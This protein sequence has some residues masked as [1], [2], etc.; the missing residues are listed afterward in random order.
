M[1]KLKRQKELLRIFLKRYFFEVQISLRFSFVS[2]ENIYFVGF[3][4]FSQESRNHL[5]D[6][7]GQIG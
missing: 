1:K 7:R 2:A 6:D 5:K 3:V 4:M